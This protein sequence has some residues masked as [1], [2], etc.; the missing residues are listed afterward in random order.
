MYMQSVSTGE[1]YFLIAR[2]KI[3]TDNLKSWSIPILELIADHFGVQFLKEMYKELSYCFCPG[4]ILELHLYSDSMISLNWIKSKVV[5]F[6]KI[7]MNA[8]ITNNKLDCIV[9]NCRKISSSIAS[10]WRR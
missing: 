3:I 8:T 5:N 10:R 4:K 2:N 6:D 9:E 1:T 7:K